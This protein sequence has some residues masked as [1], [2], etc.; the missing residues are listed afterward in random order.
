MGLI[1]SSSPPSVLGLLEE[2]LFDADALREVG[3]L[4]G[5]NSGRTDKYLSHQALSRNNDDDNPDDIVGLSGEVRGLSLW[6]ERHR[7][8]IVSDYA[9][10]RHSSQ[11]HTLHIL[12]DALKVCGTHYL[13]SRVRIMMRECCASDHLR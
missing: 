1:H 8:A 5:E 10:N 2:S 7:D 11:L 4:R 3:P 6:S 13:K 12:A 9:N